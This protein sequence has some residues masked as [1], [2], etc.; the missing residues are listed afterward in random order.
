[1]VVYSAVV[2]G[3]GQGD[4][5]MVV[6][7]LH[8]VRSSVGWLFVLLCFGCWKVQ[9]QLIMLLCTVPLVVGWARPGQRACNAR[10]PSWNSSSSTMRRSTRPRRE[11]SIT[12][13]AQTLTYIHT[14]AICFICS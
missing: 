9:G 5:G 6:V 2:C 11:Y 1:M 3:Q 12:T 14:G 7:L 10:H 4:S 13:F 8:K